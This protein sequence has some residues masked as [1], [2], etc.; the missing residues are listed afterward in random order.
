MVRTLVDKD[1]KDHPYLAP[2]AGK[3]AITREARQSPASIKSELVVFCSRRREGLHQASLDILF[4]QIRSVAEGIR[5]GL[6]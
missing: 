4:H 6:C 2:T 5:R 1:N 3:L